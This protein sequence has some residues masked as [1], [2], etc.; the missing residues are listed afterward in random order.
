MNDNEYEFKT[1]IFDRSKY[2]TS[3]F[4]KLIEEYR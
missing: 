1:N 4:K 3:E 2:N